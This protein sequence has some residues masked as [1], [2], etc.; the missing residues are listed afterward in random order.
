MRRETE[1]E[2]ESEEIEQGQRIR[3]KKLHIK[4]QK[5]N[6]KKITFQWQK[7]AHTKTLN[8]QNSFICAGDTP[9]YLDV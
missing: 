7:E 6:K 2:K 4:N 9:I 3:C 5:H 1:R 8:Y